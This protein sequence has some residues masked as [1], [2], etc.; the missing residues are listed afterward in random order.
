MTRDFRVAFAAAAVAVICSIGLAPTTQAGE[1]FDASGKRIFYTEETGETRQVVTSGGI[2]ATYHELRLVHE[3]SGQSFTY[4][5]KWDQVTSNGELVMDY[6]FN[7]RQWNWVGG[8]GVKPCKD[9]SGVFVNCTSASDA[10]TRS[11]EHEDFIYTS[12]DQGDF[13][14][15]TYK[16]GTYFDEFGEPVYTLKG[17]FPDWCTMIMLHYFFEQTYNTNTM[18]DIDARRAG[19]AEEALESNGI[20]T[21]MVALA[22]VYEGQQSG[23]FGPYQEVFYFTQ[24]EGMY[25]MLSEEQV[26]QLKDK[27]LVLNE[28]IWQ[29]TRP[30]DLPQGGF[31]LSKKE[32]KKHGLSAKKHQM[33]IQ[34]KIKPEFVA[35]FRAA[36]SE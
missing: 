20:A 9:K 10:K 7:D 12:S 33:M 16:D 29:R 23:A 35:D 31:L 11:Y 5:A 15:L 13:P 32:I 8:N 18:A 25:T 30:F 19:A 26:L 3:E 2:E 24:I 36:M 27:W 4:D 28:K 1:I 21:D 6:V 22:H 14:L 34:I 17:G